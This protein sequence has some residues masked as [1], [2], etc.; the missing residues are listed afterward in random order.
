MIKL[1]I[2]YQFGEVVPESYL[3]GFNITIMSIGPSSKMGSSLKRLQ[4][5]A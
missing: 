5:R 2:A 4:Y 3:L 1:N